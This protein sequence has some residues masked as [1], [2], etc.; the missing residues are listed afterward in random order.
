[1]NEHQFPARQDKVMAVLS[2]FVQRVV[3]ALD[4]PH[5]RGGVSL[6]GGGSDHGNLLNK[7]NYYTGGGSDHGNLLNKRNYLL[8]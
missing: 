6:P 8:K 5:A 1:M 7:R 2:Y 3:V 4:L